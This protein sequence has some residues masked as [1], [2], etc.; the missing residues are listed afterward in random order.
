M[1][2]DV[3]ERDGAPGWR[4][5]VA[6]A[7]TA[8]L[9]SVMGFSCAISFLPLFIQ[10]L[11]IDSPERAA[12]WSGSLNF[13]QAIMVAICSPIWG[14]VA[15]RYGAKPMVCRALFGGGALFVVIS[16]AGK[17]EQLVALFLLLGCFTGVNTAI[18]TLVS[19]LAP[20][21]N[22]GAAIG[23]CQTG[24]FVGVSIGPTVGGI[25]ADA[26]SYQ[27]G[28]RGGAALLLT[29]GAIV[30]LGITA[31]PTVARVGRRPPLAQGFRLAATSRPLLLLI[32]L[33]FLIQFSLTMMSPVLPIY[34]QQLSP[35]VTKVATIVGIVLGAGGMA[36]AF[37]AIFFGRA[38]DRFGQRR[39][40]SWAT[41]GG[42][43]SLAAQAL[44]A[45]IAPL[46]ALRA[47]SGL[48]TG[49]LSAGTNASLGAQ[50]P[51]GSRGAAFGVAG[52]AFSLCNAFGPLLGGFLA[53]VVGPRTVIGLSALVLCCG[54]LMVQALGRV[55]EVALV[56]Q[57][58]G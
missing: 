53:E 50:V 15:D 41:A 48:F 42:G 39:V 26:F 35:E 12:V 1:V 36:S 23:A 17:V 31:P 2:A 54:W 19:G 24:V 56:K 43:L 33:I 14:I 3:Q 30:L 27:V 18:V 32:G 5:G 22:L 16:F 51:A 20:Q 10:T 44:V 9:L 58:E 6:L 55:S 47:L 34:V 11:G 49:G 13:A 38:S 8:Q 21:K 25:L 7:V 40:L 28:I 4:R 57:P 45:S 37:G 29:A 52:S 46:V